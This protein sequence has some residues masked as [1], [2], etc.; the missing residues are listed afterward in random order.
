MFTARLKKRHKYKQNKDEEDN[1]LHVVFCDSPIKHRYDDFYTR[2]TDFDV[3]YM[4]SKLDAKI[5]VRL[6]NIYFHIILIR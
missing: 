6:Y 5:Q 2:G 1:F 4:Y 3:V